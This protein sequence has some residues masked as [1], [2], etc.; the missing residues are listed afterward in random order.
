VSLA[1][2]QLALARRLTG[3]AAPDAD[4]LPVDPQR[5]ALAA[6]MLRRKRLDEAAPSLPRTRRVLGPR[7]AERFALHAAGYRPQGPDHPGDDA[8][9]FAAALAADRGLPRWQRELAAYEGAWLHARRARP[10]LLGLR[11]AC[12]VDLSSGHEPPPPRPLLALWWRL[13]RR[14]PLHHVSLPWW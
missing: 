3:T 5:L 9:A 11:C 10:L 7:F 2:L 12:R 13:H 1:A 8:R 6:R 4:D 14:G